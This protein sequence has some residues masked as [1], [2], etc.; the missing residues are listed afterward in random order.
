MPP[1]IATRLAA[2]NAPSMARLYRPSCRVSPWH[3][4]SSRVTNPT[5]FPCAASARA[6]SS[7]AGCGLTPRQI[8]A[9]AAVGSGY[10]KAGRMNV[11]IERRLVPI[12]EPDGIGD[13]L[14]Y[15]LWSSK[16]MPAVI[17]RCVM[18]DAEIFGLGG[19]DIGRLVA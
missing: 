16:K 10:H 17:R 5:A 3:S 19:R 6:L 1:I 12:R 15:L 2:T 14:Y 18:I 7:S 9:D 11:L 8:P 13:P 4:S